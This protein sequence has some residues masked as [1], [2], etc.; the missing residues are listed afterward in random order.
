MTAVVTWEPVVQSVLD[1]LKTL[2]G[3]LLPIL[4]GIQ[5]ELGFVPP[6]AVPVIAHAMNLTRAE[7]HGVVTFYHEFRETPPGRHQ[8]H[9]CRA[10]SCQAVGADALIAHA[11]KTLGVTFH[12][13]TADGMITLEPIYCLGNCALSPAITVDHQVRG[14]VTPARFDALVAELEPGR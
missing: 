3:A 8:I 5:D 13:T 1:R 4:H 7:V 6:D 9:I 2:P 10:E 12:Q 11:E 14:R